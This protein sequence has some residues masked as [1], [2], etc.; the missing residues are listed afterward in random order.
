MNI[1]K[2]QVTTFLHFECGRHK[3]NIIIIFNSSIN[4]SYYLCRKV[5]S[6]HREHPVVEDKPAGTV[7][8]GS[9]NFFSNNWFTLRFQIDHKVKLL[10]IMK[11]FT[12]HKL[13]TKCFLT[14]LHLKKI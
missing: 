7:S 14:Y 11:N 3:R 5:F 1:K 12:A 2:Y 6:F 13:N 4:F 9:S 8:V 10:F